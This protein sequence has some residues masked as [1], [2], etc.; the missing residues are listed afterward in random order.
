MIPFVL[1]AGLLAGTTSSGGDPLPPEV[2]DQMNKLGKDIADYEH[3]K[4]TLGKE[5]RENKDAKTGK[6]LTRDEFK[7]KDNELDN[8]KKKLESAEKN[9]QFI[10]DEARKV[11][12][13][14]Y[15][16]RKAQYALPEQIRQ[17]RA[18]GDPGSLQQA[19]MLE[20]QLRA[21]DHHFGMIASAGDTTITGTAA[22]ALLA[23][24]CKKHIILSS[25]SPA[26]PNQ[27]DGRP[28]PVH[29]PRLP[30]RHFSSPLLHFVQGPG[31]K[32]TPTPPLRTPEGDPSQRADEI[33]KQLKQEYGPELETLQTE[34]GKLDDI[35][36]PTPEQKATL[37]QLEAR[38][39]QIM[40]GHIIGVL[41]PN[42]FTDPQMRESLRAAIT[43]EFQK[44]FSFYYDHG[45]HMTQINPPD[46]QIQGQAPASGGAATGQTSTHIKWKL[47]VQ[48]PGDLELN[49]GKGHVHNVHV[50]K[51]GVVDADVS[52]PNF[53]PVNAT[54]EGVDRK[55]TT[56]ELQGGKWAQTGSQT[57]VTGQTGAV[58]QTLRVGGSMDTLTPQQQKSF[59][60][61][62]YLAEL[63]FLMEYGEEVWFADEGYYPLSYRELNNE[64]VVIDVQYELLRPQDREIFRSG[65]NQRYRNLES[66]LG[67]YRFI[68][69][70]QPEKKSF[71]DLYRKYFQQY[72]PNQTVSFAIQADKPRSPVSAQPNGEAIHRLAITDEWTKLLTP[73]TLK[74]GQQQWYAFDDCGPA[75]VQ[76]AADG[77]I[78]LKGSIL[79]DSDFGAGLHWTPRVNYQFDDNYVYTG[80]KGSTA[81]AHTRWWPQMRLDYSHG[82]AKDGVL[83]TKMT[84]TP[85]V[86]LSNPEWYLDKWKDGFN[87]T[88]AKDAAGPS[89]K[90]F[91]WQYHGQVLLDGNIGFSLWKTDPET[92]SKFVHDGAF[93]KNWHCGEKDA[94]WTAAPASSFDPAHWPATDA[95]VMPH[96]EIILETP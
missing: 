57:G 2:V 45:S 73:F 91:G 22:Y 14:A 62:Q 4:E 41:Q 79:Y 67:P 59:D 34:I 64:S 3:Q 60:L 68:S 23:Q 78:D 46:F 56:W 49:D 86:T 9:K 82:T 83:T 58:R 11:A 85:A 87:D 13:D 47:P 69:V 89:A 93:A 65:Y 43:R 80:L 53:N 52:T 26:D 17:L 18:K 50:D 19:E 8:V 72:R 31:G 37:E 77:S 25:V 10:S 94:Q 74:L 30:P 1:G 44:N 63:D 35:K 75:T 88:M 6:P 21:L 39:A 27:L 15:K 70:D 32:G 42:D 20:R 90:D 92:H 7:Q 66:G 33:A 96:A 48:G 51:N 36:D 61:G 38:M 81:A 24:D 71:N 40:E 5:L 29:E 84:F 28:L 55:K 95:N 76:P 16:A 54:F 12:E